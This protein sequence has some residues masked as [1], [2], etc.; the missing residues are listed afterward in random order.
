VGRFPFAGP[1]RIPEHLLIDALVTRE[2]LAWLA[3][4]GDSGPWL[5][6]VSYSRPHFPLTAPER[7]IRKYLRRGV[8]LPPLPAGYPESAHPHDRFIVEDFS[9]L[10]FTPEQQRPALAAYYACVE[11]VDD[12]IGTLLDG[13]AARGRLDDTYV[14]Y[15]SDHGELGGE[16]G[17]W[18]K[19]S[20]YDASARVPLL[21]SGP[22]VPAGERRSEVV[23]LC[24]L[25]ATTC[26]LAG[27]P[28]P[29]G[30]DS[31]T[32]A[33]LFSAGRSS[34]RKAT[35]RSELLGGDPRTRFRMARRECWKAVEFP[36]ASP[37]LF[38][39]DADP[40][41]KAD[42]AGS[43][44]ADAPFE[45]LLAELRRGGTWTALEKRRLADRARAGPHRTLSAGSVQYRLAD[46]QLAEVDA[47]LY[48]PP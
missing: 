9:L 15:A 22:D 31:E 14:V 39:L 7:Y 33:S 16:H 23:E 10:R 19:R 46:G 24:D 28:T 2:S 47:H 4:H 26:S 20:Y 13:F 3:T 25:F 41:E 35:A 45:E 37:R 6:V 38:N 17:L 12:C 8:E 21:V 40:G 18:W 5:L 29:D 32:L 43:P 42:L 48:P 30:L 36:D 44:P 34:R 11:Y 1:T 27:V